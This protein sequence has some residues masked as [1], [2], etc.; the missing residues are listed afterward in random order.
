[1]Y[2]FFRVLL[3][4]IFDKPGISGI[5]GGYCKVIGG[6]GDSVLSTVKPDAGFGCLKSC[7]NALGMGLSFL[8]KPSHQLLMACPPSL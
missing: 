1:M 3:W 5:L 2:K 6:G 4:L 7:C 8:Q